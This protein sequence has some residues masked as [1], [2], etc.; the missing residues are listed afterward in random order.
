[1]NGAMVG[2]GNGRN[3]ERSPP[4]GA[5]LVVGA[6]ISGIQAALDLADQGLKVYLVEKRSAIGGHMAQLDKTFP[7]ND[8]A[9]CTLSPK[10][11]DAGRHPNI[12]I[13]TG[14]DVLDV[15]GE[16]GDFIATVIRRPRYVDVDKCIGCGDCA[17]VCP[18]SL[19]DLYEEGL[20]QRK[21]AYR[22]YAQAVPGAYAIEKLGTAP[23]RD[24][25]P[26][27]QRAQG[28]IA[29]I[30][31]G[32]Y[33]KALQVIKEDNPFPSACGRT[34][35]HPCE[36][37]C[38]RGQVDEPVNIMGLKRF[39][40]DFALAYGR[41]KVEPAP[42][43]QSEWVAVVGA[44]PAGLTAARD[45]A[46]LGYGVTVYE[47]LPV[48]GGMMR[49]GIPAHRLPKGVL[50][51]DIDDI[52]DLGIILKTN[53]PV[54]DPA[55]LL[56]EGYNAVCLATGVSSRDLSL[57]I[58]GEEADGVL[59]AATFLRKI[60][61]GE[62]VDIGDRVAVV[63]GGITALDAAAVARRL[64]AEVFLALDRPRGELPA[65]H[66]ELAAVEAEGI[67]LFER[68]TATR[69]LAHDGQ[70]TGVELAQAGKGMTVDEQGR[71]RPKI[72]PGSEFRLEVDTVI[73]TAGQ[74]SDLCHLDPQFEELAV[75]SNTLSSDIPGLFV[76][77]GR[78]TGAAY[79]IEAV[80]LGHRVATSIHH[81]LRGEPLATPET[82]RAPVAKFTREELAERVAR[83][84]ITPQP[85][86]EA[87]MLG[88]EERVTSFREV[89]LGLTERQA[90][91]EAQRCLQCGICSECLACVHACG[92][93]A[94][95]HN[96]RAVE[97]EL[98]VG[99]VILAPGYQVYRAELSEEY[100]YGRY[101]NVIT[102][103]QFERLLSASGPTMG[104]LQ[105]P[106]DGKQPR[107]IAFLQCVGSRDQS[108]DYCSAV[109]CMYATKEAIIAKEHH[110]E[111]DIH[112]FFMDMRA[113]S[114]GYWSY[115]Q[116]ARDRYGVVYTRCRASALHEEPATRNL[117][118]A[119]Q[120]EAG[121]R[122]ELGFDLVVLSVGMEIA[123]AVRDLGRRLGIELDQYGFCHT[124]QFN[125]LETSR[126]GIYAVG[127]FREPKDI[128]ESVVEASG[129]AAAAAARLSPSR[130][131]LT[132]KV[133]YPPERDVGTEEAR[134]GVFVCHCGSNIGGYLDVPAVA[135]FA[136]TLP[137]VVHAEASLYACS[138]D[139][140]AHISEQVAALNLNRVVIASCTPLTHLPLFQ[141][142]ARAA[143]L[144]PYLV[145]MA[146]IRNQC[147]WVHSH[148]W[149]AAT[150]K[151]R[152]L[153]QMAVARA[154]YLE[155][156]HT[157]D[158]AVERAALVVG[159]GAA[160]MTAALALADQ[161][162]P[163]HLVEKEAML[164]GNLRHVWTALPGEPVREPRRVLKELVARVTAHDK[165]TLHLQSEVLATGGFK[166]NFTS[167][168]VD[169][170]G[171]RRPVAHGATILATGGR[172]YRGPEYGYGTDPRIL[173][174]QEFERRLASAES[175]AD[176]P[177]SVVMIQ[178]VGPAERFCS[179]ICCTVALKNAL[180][181]KERRPHAEVIVLYK[182]IRTYGFKERLY[183]QAREAGILFVRYD[184]ER[185]PEVMVDGDGTLVVHAW[186]SVLR[187][188]MALQ[189]ELVVLSMPVV[190][191]ENAGEVARR[192]KVPRDADG[193]FAEAHVKLRPVDFATDGVFMAGMAH[194]PKFLDETMVQ[195][196]AAAARAARVLSQEALAAGGQVALVDPALC[197]GCLTCVR[198]CPFGVPRI[199]A[200]LRGAGGILG[201][202]HIEAAVC[203]G[204][205]LCAAECPAR[206][207]Q[208]AHYTDLQM[209]AKVQALFRPDPAFVPA[210]AVEVEG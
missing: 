62:P 133:V 136:R 92:V 124:A 209:R 156:Q 205:G 173:T 202:A 81:Y 83:G 48:P 50:Q 128:P 197:T 201:A 87:R 179:R 54:K 139:S 61:L 153:V 105:R 34:C 186:D 157:V 160:G 114:K 71:R 57:D 6:G 98:H 77:G 145:E 188:P 90:R 32:E 178:C 132:E 129:A 193:F 207:I 131:T 30:A 192:F 120:D 191:G 94:I 5:V 19:P 189:P 127:P 69:I 89:V 78:K 158:V 91:A 183:T 176:L 161:G 110:P 122:Y 135:E 112:V 134:I 155:P 27:G 148:D 109:C 111:L 166:G 165:I 101:P 117:T 95:D 143:G 41:E 181:L 167:V 15:R 22:L 195:A 174:Q 169:A 149:D 115:F 113:F 100:G 159:G 63:G 107:R 72:E 11:V 168:V 37:R 28:Y 9:M 44:G 187:R 88:M 31:R 103:L 116:R 147:S 65:Y 177:G 152:E 29:H 172:E 194:Y 196:Q 154:T 142:S 130:F 97:E 108:H 25:C 80:A 79:I 75:D 17:A 60:N 106:S 21:A 8:C 99:A 20:A 141:D 26:A 210:L 138:Q 49:V 125:P 33:R 1:M 76:V 58:D 7:T 85:R 171:A 126:A 86:V 24:G 38:S 208:L 2:K 93:N 185:R 13:L 140:I 46:K 55:K 82:A 164:G 53:S 170:S 45:L 206:A 12:T 123:P 35:H 150:A 67:T 39:V 3:G 144:N 121:Q 42:R 64:G 59:S 68:K 84:E 104:A 52:L 14:S 73:G 137:N 198:I 162:F 70:V 151:A 200:D 10:L 36:N 190:P 175:D 203:Q 182:D 119:Y 51:Q 74:F 184:D 180:A 40:V 96:M 18:V 118:V 163:V 199:E 16:A 146:N 204:C 66:W 47:A 56:Q 102:A 23:C 43:T 4:V